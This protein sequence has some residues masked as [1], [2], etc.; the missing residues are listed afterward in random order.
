MI[1][2]HTIELL[3]LAGAVA[4]SCLV[5]QAEAAF[6][7]FPRAL[8]FHMAPLS[9]DTPSLVPMAYTEARWVDLVSVNGEV[10]R[11]IVA[12]ADKQGVLGTWR[13]SPKAGIATTTR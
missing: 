11:A 12:L 6:Y 5:P 10:N 7:G 9:F 8:K 1:M 4:A 13:S 3:V 2:R